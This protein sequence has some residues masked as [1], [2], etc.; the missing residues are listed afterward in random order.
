MSGYDLFVDALGVYKRVATKKRRPKIFQPTDTFELDGVASSLCGQFFKGVFAV[1]KLP[2]RIR[3]TAPWG[4]IVNWDES[5]LPGSHWVAIFKEFEN[6]NT[7]ECF[8]S[9][10]VRKAKSDVLFKWIDAH[11]NTCLYPSVSLQNILTD[12]CGPWAVHFLMMRIRGHVKDLHEYLALYS[13]G[14]SIQN[15]KD[16][17]EWYQKFI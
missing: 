6:D 11:F 8:D 16:I 12:T 2:E 14:N 17:R 13:K 7:V 9:F 1:D 15:D 3:W 5:F 10:A 4:I